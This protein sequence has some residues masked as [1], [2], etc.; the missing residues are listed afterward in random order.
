M[1]MMIAGHETTAAMLTWATFCLATNPGEMQKC[2]VPRSF[3]LQK[4]KIS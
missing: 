1:T 3:S 2:Q 4:K